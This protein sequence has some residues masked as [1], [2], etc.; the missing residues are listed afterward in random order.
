MTINEIQD[1]L[2]DDFAFFEDWM[3]KYEYLIQL[4]KELPLIEDSYKKDEYLIKGCQSKVWLHADY[5]N[6]KVIFTADSDA[7][8]T[9]GLVGLMIKVLS[10][11]TPEEIASSE[12]YFIDQIGLKE[13]LS[14]TRANGLLSMVKQMKLYAVA[15]TVK[16]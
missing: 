15:L 6:G 8:I 7:I 13:H 10:E 1:E 14:P 3:A 2:I 5:Q 16:N 9:K 4:G 11:H 12:L